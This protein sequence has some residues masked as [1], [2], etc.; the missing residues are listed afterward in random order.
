MT[1]ATAKLDDLLFAKA[2]GLDQTASQTL[3]VFLKEGREVQRVVI[4]LRIFDPIR[5]EPLVPNEP[6]SWTDHQAQVPPQT[7]AGFL[8]RPPLHSDR[9][10][11]FRKL[12]KRNRRI[13]TAEQTAV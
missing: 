12:Q 8:R 3:G 4:P 1:L 9:N 6:T 7:P 10:R 2:I 13:E 5:I 11:H